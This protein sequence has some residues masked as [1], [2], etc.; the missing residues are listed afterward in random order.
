[1]IRRESSE[2]VKDQGSRKGY[3]ST[4]RGM[5]PGSGH[6]RSTRVRGVVKKITFFLLDDLDMH[7]LGTV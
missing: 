6:A 3:L 4:Q 5:P 1:M 7:E 2:S